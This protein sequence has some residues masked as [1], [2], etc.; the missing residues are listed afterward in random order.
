MRKTDKEQDKKRT[1]YEKGKRMARQQK[2]LYIETMK[3]KNITQH[4]SS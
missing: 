4:T 1:Y 2:I 3:K